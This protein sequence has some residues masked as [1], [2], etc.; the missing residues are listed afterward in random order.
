MATV[1]MFMPMLAAIIVQKFIYHESLK[2]PLGI[3]FKINRWFFV[4]WLL[5]GVLVLAALG[6]GLLMPGVEW[7]WEME[8]M[9]A[10]FQ[11]NL[12]LE[13]I[14][15]MKAQSNCQAIHQLCTFQI[16]EY[17]VM[18]A[19]KEAVGLSHRLEIYQ[20]LDG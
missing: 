3:S 1:Y 15:R 5:P 6:M 11:E 17:E 13:Q 20:L 14:E 8:G 9:Y 16:E 7:P 4:A 18:K 19:F 10:R 2:E 12:S